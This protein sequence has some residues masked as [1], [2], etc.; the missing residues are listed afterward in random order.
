M[1]VCLAALPITP[2]GLGVRENLFVVL[3]AIEAFKIKHAEALSLSLLGYTA[4]LLWSAVGGVV[5][6][7]LPERTA[8]KSAVAADSLDEV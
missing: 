1:V 3:L 8:L 5:Y 7:L 6:L 2:S 4:N